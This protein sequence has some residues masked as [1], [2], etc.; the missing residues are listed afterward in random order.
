[1][2]RA[3]GTALTLYV[4]ISLSSSTTLLT[5]HFAPH[6]SPPEQEPSP[7]PALAKT[8][9]VHESKKNVVAK[10]NV[11]HL[12]REN[13]LYRV[14][15][16]MGGI[17]NIQT[18]EFFE[19]HMAL[20]ES[21]A[22]AGE[23]TSAP[24]GTRTDKRTAATTFNNME[25]RGRIK[26]L[27]TAVM[28]HTGV[29]RP[30]C[31]IYLPTI[32][33]GKLNAFLADLARS[34]QPTP[35]QQGNVLKL[36]ER[37]EY[38][39]DPTSVA[40]GALPLQLLQMEE[41]GIDR[42]ERW[43]K[44]VARADQLFSYDDSVIREVLLTERTTLG[45]LYGFIVGKVVRARELHLSALGAFDTRNPSSNIISHD[46]RIVDVSFFV[47][48]IPLGLYCS[49]VSSLSHDEEL[50]R[51]LTTEQGRQTLTRDIPPNL[52]FMLQIGRSRARSR[53]LDIFEMLRS[54]KLVTPLQPS[55][56][57][58]PWLTCAPIENRPSAFDLASLEGWTVSTPMAA[59]VYWHFNDI[60]PLHIWAS[61]E[62]APPFW[63]DAPVACRADAL[64]YWGLLRE[65][66][67]NTDINTPPTSVSMTGP[68]NEDISI[69]RSLRRG[70]SWNADYV[71]TWHQMQYMRQFTKPSTANTP[72]QDEDSG[73]GQIQKISWVISA[74]QGTVRAFFETTHQKLTK[75]LQK[76]RR[77]A[78]RLTPEKRAKRAAAAKASLAKKAADAR[79]RREEE[80]ESMLLRLHPTPLEGA[81][82]VRVLR[83]R[84][85]FLQAGSTK[86]IRKWEAE[87]TEALRQADTA[88]KQVLK[89]GGKR[90]F[91]ARAAPVPVTT[92]LAAVA[93]P[94][95]KSVEALI[96]QQGPALIQKRKHK[97]KGV[98][99][100]FHRN[101]TGALTKIV[102]QEPSHLRSNRRCCVDIAFNGIETTRSSRVM[103][104]RL[105][106]L[107]VGAYHGLTGQRWSKY[108]LRFLEILCGSG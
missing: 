74:P 14:V 52:N 32:E 85:R 94:P 82:S 56:S 23:A 54:L 76:A 92:P 95:E 91:V 105:S 49:L 15:E 1:M 71:L 102:I 64:T 57:A 38:G 42:K 84:T 97:S 37:V 108:F 53:F 101:R 63:K 6:W 93:N 2:F 27:K 4:Q 90:T 20:L 89:A 35:S 3:P 36:D 18:K 70:V 40:R 33:Q 24:I 61:S 96:M 66:C 43:T 106:K 99:G 51:F 39:A 10:P 26:Q 67:T 86:D 103:L 7:A 21:M 59:P 50:T 31:I 60:A 30:A 9:E 100:S 65:A 79:N 73:E 69:A 78:E 25:R 13:E 81:A 47:H 41:P 29:R 22:K 87:V 107:A 80:W 98:E 44:N 62:V 104:L 72:L 5:D 28:T 17:V 88:S 12:R 45:Q 19:E 83:V 58:T 16:N 34:I 68:P 77:K 11:S 8:T 46:H 75:E 48:D 55:T